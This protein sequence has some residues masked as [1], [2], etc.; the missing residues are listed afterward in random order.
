VVNGLCVCIKKF[1]LD[2]EVR[3]KILTKLQ[4]H[5]MGGGMFGAKFAIQQRSSLTK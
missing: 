3:Q 1:V 2:E 5:K 4:A